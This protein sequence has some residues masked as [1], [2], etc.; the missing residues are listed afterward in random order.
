MRPLRT[1]SI[2]A[3]LTLGVLVPGCGRKP[4]G[5]AADAPG[6][7][8]AATAP[9][10]DRLGKAG[11]VLLQACTEP[12]TSF[13][14]SYKA[15]SQINPKYPMDEAAKPE[16]GPV[17]L[18]VD[19][20]PD[21]IVLDGLR[22]AKASKATAEKAKE[23][24]WA[25]TKLAL[26]GPLSDVS[27]TLAFASPVATATGSGMEG[28][29]AVDL[30]AFDTRTATAA[31]KA[32]ISMA[33]GMLGGRVKHEAISGTAAVD[34]ATGMLVKFSMDAELKDAKGHAWKEHYEGAVTPKK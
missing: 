4:S 32:G 34:K 18:E 24:D 6:A 8:A 15:Q 16:V 17:T 7:S 1:S 3:L 2:L 22:G 21:R 25:M 33:Q 27:L 5:P 13:H 14:F 11:T 20:S 19:I 10:A 23:M 9:A 31:Q 26:L 30:F 28:G 29:V 12:T